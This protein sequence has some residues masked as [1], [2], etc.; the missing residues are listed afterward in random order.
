MRHSDINLTMQTYTH[1][2]SADLNSA[3]ECLPEMSTP[4]AGLEATDNNDKKMVAGLV[5]AF[6]DI[7]CDS[8]NTHDSGPSNL[9]A[10]GRKQNPLSPKGFAVDC[11]LLN[12]HDSRAAGEIRTPDLG[13]TKTNRRQVNTSNQAFIAHQSHNAA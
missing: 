2:D 4:V 13:I 9:K 11:E 1:M 6:S 5:A 7:H 8:M 12:Q 10:E 3:V